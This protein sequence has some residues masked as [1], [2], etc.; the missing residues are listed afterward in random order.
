MLRLTDF[1]KLCVRS[2]VLP[3]CAVFH[4]QK[5]WRLGAQQPQSFV[6]LVSVCRSC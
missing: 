2:Q 4:C 5:A 3:R 1:L 6:Q